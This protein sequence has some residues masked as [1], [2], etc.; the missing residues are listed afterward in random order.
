[1]GGFKYQLVEDESYQTKIFGQDV[2][3]EYYTLSPS[4][5]LTAK[6]GFAWDGCSG[7]IDTSTNK[8]GGLFHDIGCLMVARKELP[9][10]LMVDINNMF[11]ELLLLDGMF[12]LRARWHFLAVEMHFAGNHRPDRRVVYEL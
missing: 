3:Q 2:D 12:T 8:R 1:M 5:L 7:S 10:M 4:G 6:A 11:Y 9:L